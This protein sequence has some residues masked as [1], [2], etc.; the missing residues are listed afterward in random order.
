MITAKVF[1]SG[2]SQAIRIPK[3]YRFK[4]KE[5][6]LQRNLDGSLLVREKTAA[7]E[8]YKNVV[9]EKPFVFT[10]AEAEE[11]TKLAQ[12]RGLLL[13]VYQN[14]R[15]DGDFMTVKQIKDSGRLGRLC[16]PRSRIC[17]TL[18]LCSGCRISGFSLL[19]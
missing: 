15:F 12:K 3:Q 19:L 18:P 5:V 17:K 11:L 8:G 10:V 9:V 7:A 13:T 14:R 1:Q 6:V 2:N 4:T 16:Q